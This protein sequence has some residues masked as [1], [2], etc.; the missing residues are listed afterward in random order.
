MKC[1]GFVAASIDGRIS[2]KKKRMPD[3]TSIEDWRF[4]QHALSC[5]DAVIV[6][7]NTYEAAKARLQKRTTYVLTRRTATRFRRGSV[8]FINPAGTN[9]H[10]LL[11]RHRTIAVLGGS[12]VYSWLI[13]QRLLD[14]LFVTIEP[15][16]L[17]RGTP[18]ITGLKS[19]VNARLLSSK[20]L[21]KNGTL[22]LHYRLV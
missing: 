16:V 19:T 11:H 8:V 5:M 9:V 18:M 22:L 20:K 1:T 17:G 6:G 12:E 3:W 13:D 7:R 14:E 4:F 21:N 10:D 15:I 2:L